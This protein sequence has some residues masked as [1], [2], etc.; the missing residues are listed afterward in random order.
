MLSSLEISN[1]LPMYIIGKLIN[2]FNPIFCQAHGNTICFLGARNHLAVLL[3]ITKQRAIL[4]YNNT[5]WNM[6]YAFDSDD[7]KRNIGWFNTKANATKNETLKIIPKESEIYFSNGIVEGKLTSYVEN[8]PIPKIPKMDNGIS[9]YIE[10]L[11]GMVKQIRPFNEEVL[12]LT[13]SDSAIKMSSSMYESPVY[14]VRTLRDRDR[15]LNEKDIGLSTLCLK[16]MLLIS[17]KFAS[18]VSSRSA[19]LRFYP[20]GGTQ[21]FSHNDNVSI[22]CLLTAV[23][24]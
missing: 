14:N 11:K 17:C 20:G 15:N 16:E 10:D 24:L 12:K 7:V 9:V 5:N 2:D 3:K 13:L 1:G 21:V 18:E 22:R 6:S 8:P 4:P 23:K 19:E